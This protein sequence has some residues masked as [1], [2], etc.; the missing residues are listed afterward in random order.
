MHS[1]EVQLARHDERID[2][3]ESDQAET[4]EI[5]KGYAKKMDRATWLLIS[6]L[7]G[8]IATLAHQLLK[9]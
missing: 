1:L 7:V 3:L 4:K 9:H 5:V 6:T 8:V 2:A